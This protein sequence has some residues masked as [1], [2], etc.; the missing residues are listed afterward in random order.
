MATI[1]L[2]K[3]KQVWRGTYAGSTAYTPDDVVEYTDSGILSSYICIAN[4]TGNAPSSSGTAHGSWNYLAKGGAAGANGTDVGATLANKEIAFKTNAGAVDGIPIGTAG[5]FLKVNS[6]ATGYEYGAVSSDMVKISSGTLGSGTAN[7]SIDGHFSSTYYNYKIF[8]NQLT[9]GNNGATIYARMN[10]GGSTY[11][12]TNYSWSQN[13]HYSTSQSQV[14][15]NND[16]RFRLHQNSNHADYP[17]CVEFTIFNPTNSSR[18]T[19]LLHHGFGMDSTGGAT[20][21][22]IGGAVLKIDT[23][24]TG[25]TIFS[26]GGGNILTGAEYVVYGMK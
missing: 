5:Q 17:S 4:T 22:T 2:G 10:T 14:G 18:R 16:S 25:I 9:T 8:V 13:T 1:D 24:V 23:A 7:W 21:G 20:N 15:N 26:D 12:S 6:G 19:Q 11:T 3:I